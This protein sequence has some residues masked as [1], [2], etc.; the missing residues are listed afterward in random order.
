LLRRARER[1]GKTL[2]DLSSETRIPRRHLDA[3][4]HGHL[5]AVPGGVYTRG[6]TRAYAKAVGLDERLALSELERALRAS[7]PAESVQVETPMPS[8]LRSNPLLKVAGAVVAGVFLLAIGA[9]WLGVPK[10]DAVDTPAAR[11]SPPAVQLPAAK[12]LKQTTV[13][14]SWPA[15]P[16]LDETRPTVERITARAVAGSHV[17][18]PG[19]AMDGQLVVNTSPAGARVTVDGIGWG[20]TPITIPNMAFGAKQIRISRD[21]YLSEQRLVRLDASHSAQT[22]TVDLTPA[23]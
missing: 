17:G 15:A 10:P 18:E 22:L 16:I 9:R 2:Q 13:D 14:A 8:R 6:E 7:M 21:G 20:V 5:D 3:L 23:P 11:V 1:R 12:G 4:E 19:T